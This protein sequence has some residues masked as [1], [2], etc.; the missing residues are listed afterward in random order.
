MS[1]LYGCTTTGRRKSISALLIVLFTIVYSRLFACP[2]DALMEEC[3]RMQQQQL[4][5]APTVKRRAKTVYSQR[6]LGTIKDRKREKKEQTEVTN[7][8]IIMRIL[9][10]R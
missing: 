5:K 1:F 9:R 6:N 8:E 3:V 10:M 7:G 4:Q 2:S